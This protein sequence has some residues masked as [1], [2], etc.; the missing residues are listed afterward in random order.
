MP[1][2]EE[3]PPGTPSWVDLAS[4]DLDASRRF[5]S[6]LFGWDADVDPDP[7]SAGYTMFR[8]GGRAVAGLGPTTGGNPPAWMT[9]V[10]VASAEEAVA[11]ATEGGGHVLMPPI[12]V[13]AY[14]RMAVLADTA[15]AVISVWQ[16]GSHK[17]AQV[18]SEPGTLCWNEL[19]ARDIDAAKAFYR[20]VFGWEGETMPYG[21]TSTYTQ[22]MSD[23]RAVAG[24]IQMNEAW[25][26][27]VPAHWMVYFAVADADATA[28]RAVELGGQ[29][30]VPPTD[31]PPGRLA[32]LYDPQ[33]A[34]FS[35]IRLAVPG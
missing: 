14:G 8:L 17:G 7:Q 19:A 29:V 11:A 1:E 12:D 34:V 22:W 24:M 20:R 21:D 23:G 25:P 32:V 2:M 16:P 35:I 10:T 9:Y 18:A 13:F 6:A 27:H 33:G 28:A 5:Y 30:P 15:G 26:E 31:T 3:Y 4:P